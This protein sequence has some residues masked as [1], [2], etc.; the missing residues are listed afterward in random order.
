MESIIRFLLYKM[1]KISSI[2]HKSEFDVKLD[3][4]SE[5]E[6]NKW[7]ETLNKIYRTEDQFV[8]LRIVLMGFILKIREAI[9]IWR[10]ES[11]DIN[12]DLYKFFMCQTEDEIE[13]ICEE[14]GIE[15]DIS[16]F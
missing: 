11:I 3:I 9:M 1:Y 7:I 4:K 5:N 2:I 16:K 10:N 12:G 8:D 6:W 13:Q 15:K 14:M